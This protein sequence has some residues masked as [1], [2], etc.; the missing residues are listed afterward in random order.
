MHSNVPIFCLKCHAPVKIL[1]K[2]NVRVICSPGRFLKQVLYPLPVRVPFGQHNNSVVQNFNDSAKRVNVI[3]RVFV[4]Y[5][6]VS[7]HLLYQ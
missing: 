6:M 5:I 7:R 4:S 1:P 3:N 2:K